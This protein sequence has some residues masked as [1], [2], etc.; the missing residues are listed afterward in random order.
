MTTDLKTIESRGWQIGILPA[1]GGSL[2]FGRIRSGEGWLDFMRPTPPD[3]YGD[4][5]LCASFV[6]VPYSNRI[7]EGRF[8]FNGQEYQLKVR[9]DGTSSHGVGRNYPWQVEAANGNEVRLLFK[10]TDHADVNW[11]F[12]FSARQEFKVSG[13]QFEITLSLKNEGDQPMPAGIGQH[14]YFQKQISGKSVW[15][16]IPCSRHIDLENGLPSKG[17]AAVP[18]PEWLNFSKVHPLGNLVVNHC[19]TNRKAEAPIEFVYRGLAVVKLYADP[20][21]KHIVFYAPQG[22]DFYAV[23]PVSNLND[24]FNLEVQGVPETGVFVLEPGQEKSGRMRFEI[25]I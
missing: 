3:A 22:K 9:E 23:E 5:S 6:L 18:V 24:G 13:N 14:P 10:T 25:A 21:F 19:L 7:R 8:S 20:I 2:A 4:P 1:T 16:A 17:G 12:P 15:L 11:P